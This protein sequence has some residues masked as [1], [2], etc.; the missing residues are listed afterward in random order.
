[1]TVFSMNL[2]LQKS[3]LLIHLSQVTNME[4]LFLYRLAIRHL[5]YLSNLYVGV[6]YPLNKELSCQ[7]L[8]LE[9]HQYSC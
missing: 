8:K 5:L 7:N 3:S 1:M 6:T 4:Y 9:K 2:A